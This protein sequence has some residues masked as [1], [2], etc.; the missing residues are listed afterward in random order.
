[1]QFP[2]SG[3][4]FSCRLFLCFWKETLLSMQQWMQSNRIMEINAETFYIIKLNA[5]DKNKAI[6]FEITNKIPETQ[7]MQFTV[8]DQFC[9]W[10]FSASEKQHCHPFK[11]A[12]HA[13]KW[14]HGKQSW[15]TFISINSD[16]QH[17]NKI[18][19]WIKITNLL[20]NLRQ[21]RAWQFFLQWY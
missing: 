21:D 17:Q 19:L 13:L 5:Q 1:M 2:C 10:C 15:R 3:A 20:M 4:Q 8:W 11:I 7:H 9:C 6:H 18:I 12:M 16:A 14:N